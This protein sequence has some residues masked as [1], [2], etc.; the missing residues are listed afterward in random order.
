MEN[1]PK[2]TQL[3]AFKFFFLISKH[4]GWHWLENHRKKETWL[5]CIFYKDIM[6]PGD[7]I[8]INTW[9]LSIFSWQNSTLSIYLGSNDSEAMLCIR[10]HTAQGDASSSRWSRD[11]LNYVSLGK[12][13][14]FFLFMTVISSGFIMRSRTGECKIILVSGAISVL[15]IRLFFKLKSSGVWSMLCTLSALASN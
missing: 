14:L 3:S 13:Y 12:F 11:F 7:E 10:E 1:P 9:I 2:L 4:G 8:W 6:E 15:M 5:I